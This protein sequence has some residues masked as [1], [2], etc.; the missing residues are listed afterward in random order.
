V[1]REYSKNYKKLVQIVDNSILDMEM[2][3]KQRKLRIGAVRSGGLN[4][5]ENF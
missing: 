1:D 5:T 2:L 4:M 3:K